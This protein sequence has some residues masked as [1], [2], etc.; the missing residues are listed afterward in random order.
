MMANW[1]DG[2]KFSDGHKITLRAGQMIASVS[3]LSNRWRRSCPT[4]IGFLKLLEKDNMIKR[5]LLYRQTAV[6]TICNY[7]TYQKNNDIKLDTLVDTIVDP[8]V[9]TIVYTIKQINNIEKKDNLKIISKKENDTFFSA[10]N[11]PENTPENN[12]R[13]KVFRK[14]TVD[15]VR[16]YC[17]ERNNDIDAESFVDWYESKGWKIGSSPMKDW[18]AA[19]RTWEKKN[20]Y[21][22]ES[23]RKQNQRYGDRRGYTDVTAKGPED[24][25]EGPF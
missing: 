13:R 21:K 8:L 20:K 11:T 25:S 12:P 22:N 1:E 23:N 14:P 6:L 5:E 4:V 18:K 7:E 10:D 17:S 3:F 2:E 15:E 24:Y 16:A 9:D 19:V